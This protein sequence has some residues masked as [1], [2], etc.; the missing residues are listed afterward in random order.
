MV[1]DELQIACDLAADDGLLSETEGNFL[2]RLLQLEDLEVKHVMT[3]RPDVVTVDRAWD[4]ARILDAI[5]R[6][7][8]N[9][10]PV[11][12][13]EG[14]MPVGLFHTKDLLTDRGSQPLL[15]ELRP[16]PYVPESK[17]A[18]ALLAEMRHG[19]G[20]LAAVVDEHGDFTGIVTL[21][22]CLQAFI[23]RVGDPGSGR[24]GTLAL[25]PGRWI[26]EGGLDLRQFHEETGLAL[27]PSRDYVTVAGYVMANLGRI[28]V[29]GDA[30]NVADTSLTVVSMQYSV[31]VSRCVTPASSAP[32]RTR[33]CGRE[34]RGR[35]GC[36][37]DDAGPG[38]GAAG[39]GILLGL[40]D[41]PDVDQPGA[42]SPSG[43][44]R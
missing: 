38:S 26:V 40:R 20:H 28:P 1:T 43:A 35:L 24:H 13:R 8:Y 29:V 10:F 5:R 33:R 22:D 14:A 31:A 37:Y 44:R 25:G 39:V 42:P 4:R 17:D 30:V 16:L 11:V 32:R 23:G 2:A 36:R 41:R 12:E 3:P 18:A 19:A 34:R 21:A 15:G 27:P 9:R 7:G 6:A